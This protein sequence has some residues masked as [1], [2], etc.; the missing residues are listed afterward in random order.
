M[1]KTKN[2][3]WVRG[4]VLAML[5]FILGASI[6]LGQ[7]K[8]PTT[9][10]FNTVQDWYGR[11]TQ[12]AT[13]W[14]F[15]PRFLRVNGKRY[16]FVFYPDSGRYYRTD[17]VR[18]VVYHDEYFTVSRDTIYYFNRAEGIYLKYYTKGKNSKTPKIK[19]DKMAD[20]PNEWNQWFERGFHTSKVKEGAPYYKAPS[21]NITRTRK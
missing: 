3:N 14:A 7:T 13:N 1:K 16:W 5:I 15:S 8:E 18:S 21:L 19:G 17:A 20:N 10:T 11:E 9:F 6:A 2:K 12:V 4:L